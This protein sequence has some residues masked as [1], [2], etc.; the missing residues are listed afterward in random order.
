MNATLAS[1]PERILRWMQRPLRPTSSKRVR[2]PLETGN[3]QANFNQS[4]FSVDDP[5]PKVIQASAGVS[6]GVRSHANPLLAGVYGLLGQA[7][8]IA[9]LTQR[10]HRHHCPHCRNRNFRRSRPRSV[11]W[12][13]CI[14][15][16]IPY[17]C[18]SCNRRF[19]GLALDSNP[20]TEQCSYWA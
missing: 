17:R 18:Y 2:K 5:T 3:Q 10:T 12:V 6:S 8:S 19:F 16:V 11:E 9:E 7:P 14:A 20:F 13:L 1:A 15:R 4:A